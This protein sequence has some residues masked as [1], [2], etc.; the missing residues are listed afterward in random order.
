MQCTSPGA[1]LSR[2]FFGFDKLRDSVF[3]G[4]VFTIGQG[5]S[6]FKD[7]ERFQWGVIIAFAVS[8]VAGLVSPIIMII[9]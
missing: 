2:L 8:L 4:G 3:P 1:Y 5:E 7:K 6:R 9:I